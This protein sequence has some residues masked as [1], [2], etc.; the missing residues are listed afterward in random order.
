M[1]GIYRTRVNAEGYVGLFGFATDSYC[2]LSHRASQKKV[3]KFSEILGVPASLISVASTSLVGMMAC[4]N[5]KGVALP[6]TVTKAE[7]SK[8][9]KVTD[10]KIIPGKFTALGNLVTANDKGAIVSP[11]ISESARGEISDVLG[12]KV[13]AMEIASRSEVGALCIATSKGFAVTP[14][15]S[16]EEL[17]K[18][19][20][21]FGVEGGRASASLGSKMVGCTIMANGAGLVAGMET[22]GIEL[23]YLQEA[24]GFL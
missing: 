20:K 4:G 10:A 2:F 18:L 3:S 23:Q 5:S 14:D 12:V 21:I 15:A 1:P 22:T 9:E 19:E 17:K 11:L 7:L 13:T 24:L 6:Y 16:D 8:I